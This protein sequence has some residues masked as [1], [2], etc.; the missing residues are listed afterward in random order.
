MNRR[1]KMKKLFKTLLVCFAVVPSCSCGF[2]VLLD[3]ESSSTQYISDEQREAHILESMVGNEP[4]SGRKYK[5]ARTT[6]KTIRNYTPRIILQ[7][8]F[9]YLKIFFFK[10]KVFSTWGLVFFF[11]FFLGFFGFDLWYSKGNRIEN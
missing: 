1:K 9:F 3:S 4:L 7:T 11:F 2:F 5:K 8:E 6:T 10:N